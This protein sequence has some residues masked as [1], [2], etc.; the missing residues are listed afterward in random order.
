MGGQRPEQRGP[1]PAA[2][3]DPRKVCDVVMA[4]E[5]EEP[6][7]TEAVEE[8]WKVEGVGPSDSPFGLPSLDEKTEG[9]QW[10]SFGGF[11]PSQ[12]TL[13]VLP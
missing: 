5:G 10:C 11:P 1:Q 3:A 9:N 4:E 7:L 13:I 8:Q 6:W 2:G 12:W